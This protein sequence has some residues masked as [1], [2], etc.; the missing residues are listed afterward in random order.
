LE[1]VSHISGRRQL[2]QEGDFWTVA[3]GVAIGIEP[4][5]GTAV[6]EAVVVAE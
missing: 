6:V 4:G 3:A 2:R 1:R 5:K